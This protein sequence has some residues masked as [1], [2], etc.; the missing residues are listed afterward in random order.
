[1]IIQMNEFHG[2]GICD[3]PRKKKVSSLRIK[4]FSMLGRE[5]KQ[6]PRRESTFHQKGDKNNNGQGKRNH[7]SKREK[8]CAHL[9]CVATKRKEKEKTM[10]KERD[11]M[12]VKERKK[13]LT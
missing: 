4:R 1:M 12:M 2:I 7:F 6:W 13:I 3:R 9:G 8:T 5:T 10:A 11:R